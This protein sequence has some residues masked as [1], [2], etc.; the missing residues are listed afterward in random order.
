[1]HFLSIFQSTLGKEH[2]DC[3]VHMP[4]VDYIT[5]FDYMLL[6]VTTCYYML[7]HVTTCYYMLLLVTTCYYMLLHATTCYYMRHMTT[8]IWLHINV[9][10]HEIY[11][12]LKPSYLYT[13][14]YDNKSGFINFI[15]G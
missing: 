6:H 11:R 3:F 9:V 5:T 7:L 15:I 14:N 12:F 2:S 10:T 1:M 8:L 13:L 4:T